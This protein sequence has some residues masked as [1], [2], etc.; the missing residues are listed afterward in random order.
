MQYQRLTDNASII[1]RET[2]ESHL[3]SSSLYTNP[4]VC[5]WRKIILILLFIQLIL[6]T[7]LLMIDSRLL[8]KDKDDNYRQ[9]IRS[10]GLIFLSI[11]YYGCGLT[12]VYRY[13]HL[14]I[15]VFAWLGY[16]QY[17]FLCAEL[18]LNIIF[19]V[20]HPSHD[21]RTKIAFVIGLISTIMSTLQAIL[22]VIT[23]K[24]TFKLF[25]LIKLFKRDVL[26]QV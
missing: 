12:V 3:L 22:M 20:K 6:C 23:L 2:G 5:R 26:E 18:F 15:Y 11:V 1:V 7:I 14:G 16:L 21:K 8:I 19:I 9:G 24:L 4:K 25:H 17:I 13:H 10:L